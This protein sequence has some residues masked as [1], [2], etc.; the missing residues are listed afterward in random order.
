MCVSKDSSA[1]CDSRF[2]HRCLLFQCSET[3]GTE[4][5]RREQVP[6]SRSG[7]GENAIGFSPF[8][9]LDINL[10]YITVV[11]LNCVLSIPN[12]SRNVII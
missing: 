3:L 2:L 9:M 10:S 6:L 5:K 8:H 1:A 12:F 11:I 4:R 7:L